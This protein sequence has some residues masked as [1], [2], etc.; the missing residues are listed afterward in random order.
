MGYS[1][2]LE[3]QSAVV[4][5]G[6]IVGD[7]ISAETKALK[8]DGDVLVVKVFKAAWRQQLIF[9]KDDLLIKLGNKLGEG[10][11]KDIRFI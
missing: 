2:R 5:W 10:R 7:T 9:L 1:G 3:K 11:V 6:D 4:K 8:I